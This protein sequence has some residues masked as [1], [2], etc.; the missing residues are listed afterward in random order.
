MMPDPV[1]RV[2]PPNETGTETR[3]QALMPAKMALPGFIPET[4]ADDPGPLR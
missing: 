3:S 1:D 2:S 4:R